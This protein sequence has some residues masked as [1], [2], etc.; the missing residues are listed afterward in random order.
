M[1]PPYDPS[2]PIT[3]P[4]DH[5][6]VIAGL[7]GLNFGSYADRFAAQSAN[8]ERVQ[9]RHSDDPPYGNVNLFRTASDIAQHDKYKDAQTMVNSATTAVKVAMKDASKNGTAT[10]PDVFFEVADAQRKHQGAH[11][12]EADGRLQCLELRPDGYSGPQDLKTHL[13]PIRNSLNTAVTADAKARRYEELAIRNQLQQQSRTYAENPQLGV[14]YVDRPPSSS[15]LHSSQTSLVSSHASGATPPPFAE[16]SSIKR[17]C[18]YKSSQH[19]KQC[20]Q[21]TKEVFCRNHRSQG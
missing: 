5:Q 13:V 17:R 3:I 19:G 9:A 7:C 4:A 18:Q 2:I 6:R 14:G 11:L 1:G 8:N 12:S 15:T 21:Y 16:G 20:P 10:D